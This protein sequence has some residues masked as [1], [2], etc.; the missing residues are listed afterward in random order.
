M[1]SPGPAT[2]PLRLLALGDSYTIGEAVD[3]SG[4]WPV[5]LAARLRE[6][7]IPVAEPVIIART[8][9]STAELLAAIDAEPPPGPFDLVSLLIGVNDQYRGYPCDAA[10]R[11]RVEA[12]TARAVAFTGG[13]PHRV[14][15]LSIPDWGATPFAADRDRARIAAEVDA[16]NAANRAVAYAA[17]ASWVDVTPISREAATDPTLLAHDGLHP[18]AAMYA[19]WV[20]LLL[21]TALRCIAR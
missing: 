17:R 5:Q 19:R 21:P 16:F 12:L 15:A 4:R 18:S 11:S 3:P 2:P 10:Y 13:R 1:Q 7:G 20:E 9:W 8:G 14:I 6:H